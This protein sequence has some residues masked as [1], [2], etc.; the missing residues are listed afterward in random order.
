ML[1]FFAAVAATGFGCFA[2]EGFAFIPGFDFVT[3]EGVA[4][5]TD[6][7]V[8]LNDDGFGEWH[9]IDHTA[10]AFGGD[11]TLFAFGKGFTS[12]GVGFVFV[13]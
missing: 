8:E 11:D 7:A 6:F 5:A 2:A 13:D 3:M 10:F 12:G 9:Y 4:C 1:F